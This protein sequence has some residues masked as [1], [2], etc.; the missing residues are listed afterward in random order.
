MH[1]VLL[2]HPESK[3]SVISHMEQELI[4]AFERRKDMKVTAVTL[5]DRGYEQIYNL[6][7]QRIVD[8]TFSINQII[9]S[10][11]FFETFG[12]PH[13]HLSLDSLFWC[14]LDLLQESHLVPCFVDPESASMWHDMHQQKTFW[15]PHACSLPIFEDYSWQKDIPFL[16]PCSYIDDEHMYSLWQYDWG[17]ETATLLAREAELFLHAPTEEYFSFLHRVYDACDMKDRISPVVFC[18]SMD[19]YLRGRDRANVLKTLEGQTVNIASDTDAF[20]KYVRRFPSVEFVHEGE[21]SFEQLLPLFKRARCVVNSLPT[22]R[23]GLHERVLYALAYGCA[24]YS[25]SMKMLPS[26]M[27]EGNMVAFYDQGDRFPQVPNKKMH[28]KAWKWIEKEHT[29]D[30]RIQKLLSEILT[31]AQ[32]IRANCLAHNPFLGLSVDV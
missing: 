18:K 19:T 29:W 28:E 22:L 26:W 21:C 3:Y 5:D 11:I 8:C 16:F 1:I 32:E 6:M 23:C 7:H 2:R 14:N 24:L 9:G 15:F 10:A 17:A 13:I 4:R 20:E 25:S 27:H 30:V 12:V 31:R